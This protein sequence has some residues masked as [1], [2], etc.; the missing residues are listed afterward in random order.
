MPAFG[1]H[2][3]EYGH[4]AG[5]VEPM[6]NAKI[7]GTAEQSHLRESRSCDRAIEFAAVERAEEMDQVVLRDVDQPV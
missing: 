1:N 3:H 5:S 4:G 7:V 2:A 6:Q